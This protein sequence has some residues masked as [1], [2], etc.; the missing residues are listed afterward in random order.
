MTTTNVEP[1]P[2]TATAEVENAA[3]SSTSTRLRAA[4]LRR[5]HFDEVGALQ[6]TRLEV[7]GGQQTGR[8]L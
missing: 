5:P 6:A 4:L 8:R 7:P 1:A 2:S 3:M